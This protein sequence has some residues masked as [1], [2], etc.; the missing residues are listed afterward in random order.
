MP[1]RS[2]GSF[3]LSELTLDAASGF[4]LPAEINGQPVRLRVDL[5]TSAYV[6]LNPDAASRIGLEPSLLRAE[7]RIGPVTLTGNSKAAEFRI[8]GADF[9]KRIVW[10]DRPAVE[11]ADGLVGPA[12]LPY[13]RVTFN[14]AP[15]DG[16]EVEVT[17]PLQYDAFGL[18]HPYP[19]GEE[20]VKFQFSV[21]RPYSM[22]TAAAGSVL[23]VLHGGRWTG[24][25]REQL[26]RYGVTRPVRPFSLERPVSLSGFEIDDFLVRT[27]DNRGRYQLAADGV[28]DPEELVVT[29]RR[30]SRQRPSFVVTLGR[31]RLSACSSITYDNLPRRIILR[32]R[33]SS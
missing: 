14:L 22:A 26:I 21:L 11:G 32:C 16:D 19:V 10:V 7:T 6:I 30:A 3:P 27:S 8:G 12:E 18:F 1:P 17:L 31:D 20:S 5:E 9:R 4:I 13:R 25:A 15:P 24:D 28:A 2:A 23:S 33:P 29:A